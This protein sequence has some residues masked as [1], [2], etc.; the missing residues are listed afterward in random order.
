MKHNNWFWGIFF[1]LAAIFVIASQVTSFTVIGFWPIAATVLLAAIFIQSLIKL[2]FFGV[3]LSL[4][5]A[6]MIYQHTLGW[7]II[8]PWLL[9]LAA[10]LVS[11]GFHII[12][13]RQTKCRYEDR[14]DGHV[15]RFVD[16]GHRTME[17]VD[18]NN[19]YVKLSFGSSSKYIHAD[20]LK[21]GQFTC[22][23]G[24][25]SVY[26]D[27]AQLDPDGA[28]IYLDCSFGEIKLYCPREWKI[29]DKLKAS[30]GGVRNDLRSGSAPDSPTVV[31]T[32]GTSLGSI[33]I[34]YI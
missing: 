8:S 16:D 13:G 4:A 25:L 14:H 1:V 18:G 19:P 11:T 15:D 22:S 7:Y 31:L 27:Q 24:A 9:I 20:A 26:F 32:G 17:D 3:F 2:N 29:V 34:L 30:L 10:I 5:L 6:Y 23:F 28:E 21:S 33:E 12:F